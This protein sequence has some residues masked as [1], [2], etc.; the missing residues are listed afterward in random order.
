MDRRI[1]TT[2]ISWFFL[3]SSSNDSE[4]KK[5]RKNIIIIIYTSAQKTP[6][7]KTSSF[8]NFQFTDKNLN[9]E[10]TKNKPKIYSKF[11][12]R[13]SYTKMSQVRKHSLHTCFFEKKRGWTIDKMRRKRKIIRTARTNREN[14][15][16]MRVER[17]W[18]KICKSEGNG[19]FEKRERVEIFWQRERW[20]RCCVDEKI[21]TRGQTQQTQQTHTNNEQT[22]TE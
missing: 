6:N 5:K 4:G 16:V 8:S 13:E 1:Y 22:T 19:W 12:K 11:K 20:K 15:R 10:P 14:Y 17:E 7:V 2:T 9:R 18:E 21:I 3:L